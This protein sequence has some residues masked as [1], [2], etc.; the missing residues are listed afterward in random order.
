MPSMVKLV[1][2]SHHFES[3]TLSV[4]L[5]EKEYQEDRENLLELTSIIVFRG[6]LLYKEDKRARML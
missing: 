6:S 5:S 2:Q 1:P 3:E 4:I